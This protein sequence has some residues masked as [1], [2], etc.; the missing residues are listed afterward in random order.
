MTLREL[1]RPHLS[2]LAPALFADHT[3]LVLVPATA[4]GDWAVA[5]AWDVARAAAGGDRRVALVDLHLERPV[6]DA[7]AAPTGGE[8]I[9]DAF[10]FGASLN[11]VAVPQEP[12]TLHFIPVGTLPSSAAAVW[13]HARWERL[14][15]GFAREGALLLAYTPAHA[16][17]HLAARPDGA[18]VLAPRG[19]DPDTQ[20]LPGL[21]SVQ[22]PI[23]G[24]VRD[25]PADA[26]RATP[27]APIRAT[28]AG[29][30]RR[31]IRGRFR[32]LAVVAGGAAI[33]LAAVWFR[34]PL[35]PP[36]AAPTTEPTVP[37]PDISDPDTLFYVVQVAAFSR[38][39]QALDH[40]ARL[41]GPDRPV[42]V[43]P[44]RLGRRETVW[45]RV[46]VGGAPTAAASR[47]LLED[48][49]AGGLV[50][51]GQ[52]TILRTPHALEV[53]A[54]PAG[55]AGDTVR[56]LRRRGLPAYI[57]PGS[58]GTARVLIGAFEAPEQARIADSLLRAAGVAGTL[59]TRT[60]LSV[61]S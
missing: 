47:R 11:H 29:A 3:F 36:S 12:A 8:G 52:G 18:V 61:T 13:G 55:E 35:A 43:T 51:R 38:M 10:E 14:R 7:R 56:A 57:V 34:S 25:A 48:L 16:L 44:V 54:V 6:L 50:D 32:L 24:V 53:A 9:V 30:A 20:P 60:G 33:V 49:W 59:V 46:L 4:D 41:E 39:D 58:G 5:A 45:Y 27:V 1:P 23:V 42:T 31:T 22:L 19:Y 26:A 21:E 40:A 2:R 37:A 15:R 28:P 17:P